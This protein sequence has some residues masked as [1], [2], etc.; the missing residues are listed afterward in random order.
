MM[1]LDLRGKLTEV[2]SRGGRELCS[3]ETLLPGDGA[4]WGVGWG[5]GAG[6]DGILVTRGGRGACLRGVRESLPLEKRAVGLA[7]PCTAVCPQATLYPLWGSASHLYNG[8]M[9]AEGHSSSD[10][11]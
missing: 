3:P 4:V 10:F 6:G 8:G 9:S 7:Q 11:W 5:A 2:G 1:K